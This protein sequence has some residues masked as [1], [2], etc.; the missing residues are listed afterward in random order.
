MGPSLITFDKAFRPR[1][2]VFR[3]NCVPANYITASVLVR[4]GVTGVSIS[5]FLR[6]DLVVTTNASYEIFHI[7]PRV[8]KN[9]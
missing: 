5:Y 6:V 2:L 4:K 1:D 3:R 9:V 7:M 8:K